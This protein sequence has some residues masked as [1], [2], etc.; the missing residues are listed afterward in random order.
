MGGFGDL[1]GGLGEMLFGGAGELGIERAGE[2]V[3]E[4]GLAALGIGDARGE[5]YDATAAVDRYLT[6]APRVLNVNDI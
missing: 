2:T 4:G 5:G 1:L 3:V 6:G